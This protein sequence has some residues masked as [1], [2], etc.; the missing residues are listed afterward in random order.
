MSLAMPTVAPA[1]PG[2]VLDPMVVTVGD[3]TLMRRAAGALTR[4]GIEVLASV[5]AA[6]EL[7]ELAQS[8]HPHVV[9]LA[10]VDAREDA[11]NIR[12]I[13][14]LL[15][16]SRVIIALR[17][18]QASAVRGALRAG[19]DGVV[20]EHQLAMSLSA[21]VRAVALGHAV[22]P[23]QDRSA[24]GREP[25]SARE[26]EVLA[27]AAGGL[28]NA[29]IAAR[30]HLSE[31]TVKSH[32]SSGFSKLGL[33]SRSELDVLIREGRGRRSSTASRTPDLTGG[34]A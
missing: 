1:S 20:L 8:R 32:V 34:T 6:D 33:H 11:A 7:E 15:P 30:L 16:H 10:S 28:T 5:V 18:H 22:V 24:L 29:A 21:V 19:A 12:A 27:L 3:E 31:S 26:R 17:S 2:A 25:L 9:L 14:A 13:A 23:L 4:Q